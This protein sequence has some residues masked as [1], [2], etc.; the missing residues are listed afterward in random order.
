MGPFTALRSWSSHWEHRTVTKGVRIGI[1][2][3]AISKLKA[4]ILS[5]PFSL[6]PCATRSNVPSLPLVWVSSSFTQTFA[7]STLSHLRETQIPAFL[8]YVIGS[9]H[10]VLVRVPGASPF[11][12]PEIHPKVPSKYPFVKWDLALVVGLFPEIMT[13]IGL[14]DYDAGRWP[15]IS[16]QELHFSTNAICE[17]KNVCV[18]QVCVFKGLVVGLGLGRQ[19]LNIWPF[20]VTSCNWPLKREGP[21]AIS[22]GF[23]RQTE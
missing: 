13:A 16:I 4:D 9:S 17:M 21:G 23:S 6:N 12:E 1:A 5:K 3:G 11:M 7:P 18:S 15:L 2:P 22:P 14:K 19:P 10:T 20:W 8:L